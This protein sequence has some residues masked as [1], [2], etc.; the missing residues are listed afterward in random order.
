MQV[1]SVMPGYGVSVSGMEKSGTGY[2]WQY[3][4]IGDQC[5]NA[6]LLSGLDEDEMR[7]QMIFQGNDA[8][9]I[10]GGKKKTFKFQIARG[11]KNMNCTI[12]FKNARS[13]ELNK[14]MGLQAQQ[15]DD[16]ISFQI[17]AIPS[18]IILLI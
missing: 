11:A 15:P 14:A 7:P 9:M 13:W 8:Q 1:S 2:T 18:A 17:G 10:G 3:E 4:V 6:V 12:A 16:M 5:K